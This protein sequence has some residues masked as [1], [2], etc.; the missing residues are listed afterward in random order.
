ML[1]AEVTKLQEGSRDGYFPIKM[2]TL[3]SHVF[4]N[5]TIILFDVKYS[6]RMIEFNK[7]DNESLAVHCHQCW[8]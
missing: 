6:I 1:H 5:P 4:I 7:A 2:E 3:A 8:Q